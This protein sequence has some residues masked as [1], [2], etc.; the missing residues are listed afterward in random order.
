VIRGE[1]PLSIVID[2]ATALATAVSDSVACVRLEPDPAAQWWAVNDEVMGGISSGSIEREPGGTL[3]FAGAVSFENNGGFASVRRATG[4][5]TAF[6]A[7]RLVLLGDGKRYK[8]TAYAEGGMSGFAYQAPFATRAGH[9]DTVDLALA[10]FRP[11]FRG[12]EVRDA[13][14]LTPDR[15]RAVGL[16]ISDKQGGTFRL[17]VGAID[18]L[19]RG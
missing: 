9:R 6:D 18:L 19:K 17:E 15:I 14:A 10:A 8:L 4:S 12:R 13:P 16:L 11:T 1:A 3:V 2:G 7:F 5:L